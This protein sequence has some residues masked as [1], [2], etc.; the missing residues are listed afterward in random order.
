MGGSK[1]PIFKGITSINFGASAA[2]FTDPRRSC[3]GSDP[4]LWFA[5]GG[6]AEAREAQRICRTC[7]VQPACLEYA[8]KVYAIDGVWGGT[9]QTDRR[10][11]AKRRKL[12]IDT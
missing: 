9:T 6:S 3:H 7:P 11:L 4:E 12:G 5:R 8:M 10:K 1:A 2:F